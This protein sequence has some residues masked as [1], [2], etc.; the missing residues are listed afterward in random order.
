M[1]NQYFAEGLPLGLAQAATATL[2]ALSVVWFAQRYGVRIGK[3]TSVAMLR[4]IVQIVAVGSVLLLL[5]QGP[6]WTAWIVLV[7]MVLTASSIAARRAKD[8]PGA[9]RVSLYGIGIGGGIVIGLMTW[10]GVIDAA[11][12]SIIPVGSMMIANAMNTL[13]LA[14]ERFRAE[15]HA[16]VGEIEAGL[17]LGADPHQVVSPYVQAAVKASMI[18]RVDALR[19]LG[20]VWIPGIMAGMV[21]S[22]TDPVYAAVY[23]FVVMAMIFA[24][25]GLSSLVGLLLIRKRVFSPAEQLILRP[26]ERI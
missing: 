24:V 8:I 4:G 26:G 13:A 23:Q 7:A 16:H 11:L 25:G 17:A 14:L 3:E 18:P 21:L 22:G 20:I 15:V 10:M 12:T 6:R 2:M 5:L 9:L 19:S 1:L